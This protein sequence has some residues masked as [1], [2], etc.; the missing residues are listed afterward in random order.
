MSSNFSGVTFPM[1]KVTPSDD[2]IV[3]RA[4]LPDGILTGCD[5]SYSGSTLTMAAGHLMICGRQIR[6]PASQN[7]PVVDATS[8]FAR[9]VLTIDLSQTS[10][11]DTFNLVTAAI[12]YASSQD[13]FPELEQTDINVSGT[14]YQVSVCVVSLG[15]GGI[16]GIVNQIDKSSADGAGIN[17]KLVGGETQPSGP[18]ENMIWVNTSDPITGYIFSATQPTE[19]A[20]GLIW[21]QTGKSSSVAFAATKKNP[22]YVYPIAVKQYVGGTWVSKSAKSYIGGE[23]TNWALTIYDYGLLDI[24]FSVR[25]G[26]LVQNDTNMV[27]TTVVSADTDAYLQAEALIDFSRYSQITLEYDTTDNAYLG[28][29]LRVVTRSGQTAT[30]AHLSS[31]AVQNK[32]IVLDVS[33]ISEPG[34]VQIAKYVISSYTGGATKATTVHFW[35]VS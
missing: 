35:E 27:Y 4:I 29:S 15:P 33:K 11:L 30:Y 16:T 28:H 12:E 25:N 21:I 23:W 6:H 14:K 8:G 2:A 10:T 20:E 17:F 34:Y 3:R 24:T 32:R 19:P 18:S 13:G 9:L 26:T 22:I 31:T 1:Q 7:W 5:I